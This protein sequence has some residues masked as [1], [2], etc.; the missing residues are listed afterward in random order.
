MQKDFRIWEDGKEQKLTGFSL[1]SLGVS[2]ERPTRHYIAM[3]FD[4]S[5]AA[6]TTQVVVRQEAL[7]FVDGFASPDRYMAVIDYGFD[8]GIHIAQNFTTDRDSAQERH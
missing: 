1:E 3:F 5:T 7:R 8:S 2:P 4:T 6:Q